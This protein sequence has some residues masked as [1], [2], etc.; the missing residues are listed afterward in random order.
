MSRGG[1]A[2]VAQGVVPG[3]G[4]STPDRI[5]DWLARRPTHAHTITLSYEGLSGL[6]EI[7]QQDCADL[8]ARGAGGM[9]LAAAQDHAD[10]V[11][12]VGRY[13]LQLRSKE[14]SVCGTKPVRVVP[15]GANLPSGTDAIDSASVAGIIG[16]TLRHNETVMRLWVNGM[17]SV[18]GRMHDLLR[19]EQGENDL[20]R[21]RMRELQIDE[22]DTLEERQVKK[23]LLEKIGTLA[24]EVVL[25]AALQRWANN[26][27]GPPNNTN[28]SGEG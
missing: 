14:G 18:L 19:L 10:D 1:R 13:I 21:R 6:E 15:D 3:R 24:T 7:E 20:L 5:D 9:L 12:Q 8:P 16:Q 27:G 2:Y 26:G 11:G 25:P 17:G 22:A 28:G 4:A 23:E